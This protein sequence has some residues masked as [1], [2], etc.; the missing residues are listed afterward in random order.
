[1]AR[2]DVTTAHVLIAVAELKR[3]GRLPGNVFD[4]L[5]AWTG[6]TFKVCL[7]AVEREESRRFI[8]SGTSLNYPWLTDDG[9]TQIRIIAAAT[10]NKLPPGVP[11]VAAFHAIDLAEKRAEEIINEAFRRAGQEAGRRFERSV[12]DNLMGG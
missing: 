8:D 1:M 3:K 10:G 12:W 9:L 5:T 4:L 6:Q 11:G 7:R 2:K